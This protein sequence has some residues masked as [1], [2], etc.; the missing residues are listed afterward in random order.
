[1]H[2]CKRI[3]HYWSLSHLKGELILGATH[4]INLGSYFGSI[5]G[6]RPNKLQK[7]IS[8]N[9]VPCMRCISV[10]PC[11]YS[12]LLLQPRL[13]KNKKITVKFQNPKKVNKPSINCEWIKCSTF[14]WVML[15][16]IRKNSYIY[17][18]VQLRHVHCMMPSII[19]TFD[20][21]N[22]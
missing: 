21:S 17:S 19:K 4:I 13:S 10:M 6:V 16:V 7:G 8:S 2:G 18:T 5:I 1:M 12:F 22:Y 15:Y 3:H 9:C 20:C 11:F 14:C